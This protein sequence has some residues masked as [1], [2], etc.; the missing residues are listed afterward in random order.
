MDK[1]TNSP[2]ISKIAARSYKSNR[3]RN[4]VAIIAI[5][6]TAVMFATIFTIG[7]SMIQSMENLGYA[8]GMGMDVQG[9]LIMIVGIIIVL[10]SGYLI[11]Y[12]IFQISVAQDI[13]FYGLLKTLG[14]TSGQIG[15]ILVAQAMKLCL[16]GIPIGLLIGYAVGAIIMPMVLVSLGTAAALS[17]NP[18]IFVAAAIFALVTVLL[19]CAKPAKI[20][21]RVSPVTAIKYVD[22]E[23]DAKAHKKRTNH[24]FSLQSM[25]SANLKRNKKRTAT[26]VISISLGLMLMNSFYVMQHSYDREAYVSNFLGSDIA[27]AEQ[28]AMEYS[29]TEN[30]QTKGVFTQGALDEMAAIPGV[31]QFGSAYYAE[32]TERMNEDVLARLTSYYDEPDSGQQGWVE[33]DEEVSRQYQNLKKTGE[34]TVSVY[35]LDGFTAKMGNVYVG[36]Y[37]AEKFQT[38][39]YVI[40]FGLANNGEGS[41]HYEVGDKIDIAGKTYELMAMMEPVETLWGE[42]HSENNELEIDYAI[43]AS[44]FRESFPDAQAVSA[45]MD[46]PNVETTKQVVAQLEQKFPGMQVSTWQSYEARFQSQVLAQVIMGYTLGIIMALIGIL[47]FVNSM[48]TAIIARKREFAMLES[49]GMTKPQLKKMLVFEGID[50]AAI[51]MI[52]SLVLATLVATTVIQESVSTSWVAAYSFSLMPFAIIAP[53]MV[54]LAVMIPLACFKGTQKKS[55]VERLR[56]TE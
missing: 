14:A 19:S 38:G 41:V 43:S 39:N 10:I 34:T 37:D 20:A 51:S 4:L 5:I 12:N 28:G 31:E 54:V 53:I 6:L 17:F 18:M 35:G 40:A 29:Y 42:F 3:S 13:R 33:M 1:N 2:I 16:I 26:V 21:G 50:Y 15:R 24:H 7:F 23:S 55:L 44:A 48:L 52:I 8:G 32:I 56:E 11:I 47:N 36:K 25:A 30:Y 9:T 49:V 27:I 46:T 45:F 22:G